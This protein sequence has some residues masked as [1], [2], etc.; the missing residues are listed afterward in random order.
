[1]ATRMYPEDYFMSAPARMEVVE[2][3]PIWVPLILGI[4]IIGA[5][6]VALYSLSLNKRY[7]GD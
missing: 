7:E 3:I 1:M 4:C 5:F 6:A 2:T